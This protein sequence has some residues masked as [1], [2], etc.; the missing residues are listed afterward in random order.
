MKISKLH[1]EFIE[2]ARKPMSFGGLPVTPKEPQVPLVVS[3][4][5]E[6]KKNSL[7]K[8]YLFRTEEQKVEFVKDLLDHEQ[9]VGHHASITLQ[10]DTVELFLQTKDIDVVTELDKE[11]AKYADELYKDI[12]Y[13]SGHD[14]PKF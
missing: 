5:W 7:R 3:N 11:Y 4:K 1:E 6:K 12:V 8:T 9:E 2:K 13:S 14:G 10:K